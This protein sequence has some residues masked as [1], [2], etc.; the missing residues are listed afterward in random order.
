MD[1]GHP[2]YDTWYRR[3]PSGGAPQDKG[4]HGKGLT[5]GVTLTWLPL[6]TAGSCPV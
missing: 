6:W 5:P 1:R 4:T 2:R 3:H